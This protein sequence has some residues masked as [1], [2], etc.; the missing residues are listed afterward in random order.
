M[1]SLAATQCAVTVHVNCL[2]RYSGSVQPHYQ[3]QAPI[4]AGWEF[5][6][7]RDVDSVEPVG[8]P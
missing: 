4:K 2:T 7:Q 3:V 5:C 8:A 6:M 1:K